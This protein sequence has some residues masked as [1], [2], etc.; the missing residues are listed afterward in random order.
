[1]IWDV[2]A[3]ELQEIANK[4]LCK[5]A[6]KETREVVEEMCRLAEGATP[7]LTGLL[8]PMCERCGGV[9]YEMNG[10]CGKN[11]NVEF[12]HVVHAKWIALEDCSNE[13]VYCS[14][15]QKKAYRLDYANQKLKSKFCPNCGAN[16]D[17]E[18]NE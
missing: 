3:E 7:E 6:A 9:C 18:N 4:R 2:N 14:C 5:M 13:G 11:K 1:M 16:M 8:V 12:A 10:G 17:V 15:C